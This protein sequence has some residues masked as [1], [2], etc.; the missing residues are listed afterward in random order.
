MMTKAGCKTLRWTLDLAGSCRW[1]FPC[2][3]GHKAVTLCEWQ[4]LSAPVSSFER[5]RVDLDA[6]RGL[7]TARLSGYVVSLESC[8][9]RIKIEVSLNIF[10]SL[11][12]SLSYSQV[13]LCSCQGSQDRKMS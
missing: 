9:L 5:K 6:L 13:Q 1:E 10:A 11:V 8:M 3:L 2:P 4:L 12:S 7:P